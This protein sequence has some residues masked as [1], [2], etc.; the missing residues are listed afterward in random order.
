MLGLVDHLVDLKPLLT[1]FGRAFYHITHFAAE[2]GSSQR[3]EN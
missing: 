3:L 1:P 2:K